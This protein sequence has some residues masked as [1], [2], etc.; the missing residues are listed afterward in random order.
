MTKHSTVCCCLLSRTAGK[1]AHKLLLRN[2]Q[3]HAMPG[4]WVCLYDGE[5]TLDLQFD[6]KVKQGCDP[7]FDGRTA[8]AI[9]TCRSSSCDKQ[10]RPLWFPPVNASMNITCIG[11]YIAV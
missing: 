11:L 3:L 10:R 8:R 4:R 9:H 2:L 6:A 7:L 1:L 5:G